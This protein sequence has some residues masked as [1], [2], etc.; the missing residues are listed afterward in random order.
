M[1]F[2]THLVVHGDHERRS[3]AHVVGRLASGPPRGCHAGALGLASKAQLL[4][5]QAAVI[6]KKLILLFV[7]KLK[8]TV[9]DTLIEF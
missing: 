2:G 8:I 1:T 3:V 4:S 7:V 6:R 5:D 9:L